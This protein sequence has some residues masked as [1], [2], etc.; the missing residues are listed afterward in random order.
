ML[1]QF[2]NCGDDNVVSGP[3]WCEV[4]NLNGATHVGKNEHEVKLISLNM[5]GPIFCTGHN[6]W[7]H[8]IKMG[9]ADFK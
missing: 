3:F 7:Q 1:D 6:N 2:P 4:P 8:S 9:Y 5:R